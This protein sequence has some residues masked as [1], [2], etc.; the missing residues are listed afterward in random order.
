MREIE[1]MA[2]VLSRVPCADKTAYWGGG[3]MLLNALNSTNSIDPA[4]AQKLE[5]ELKQRLEME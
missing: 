2:E 4:L 3:L 5:K 1:Y